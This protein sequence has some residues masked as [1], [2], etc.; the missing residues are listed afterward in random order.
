MRFQRKFR[1]S[2]D[3]TNLPVKRGGC[4]ELRFVSF[5]FFFRP[6]KEKVSGISWSRSI[7][8]LSHRLPFDQKLF[9]H[10]ARLII[11]CA[12]Q[13]AGHDKNASINLHYNLI[14][15]SPLWI[16]PSCESLIVQRTRRMPRHPSNNFSPLSLSLSLLSLWKF[17]K[18]KG[19]KSTFNVQ[20]I[21]KCFSSRK[22]CTRRKGEFVS[23][24]VKII[25]LFAWKKQI[26]EDA[27][28]TIRED[29]TS[30]KKR[31][32]RKCFEILD[33][34][35]PFGRKQG[36]HESS[37]VSTLHFYYSTVINIKL[38]NCSRQFSRE[39]NGCVIVCDKE[40]QRERERDWFSCWCKYALM[41]I[42]SKTFDLGKYHRS[43][44][45]GDNALYRNPWILI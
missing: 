38:V 29:E 40:T 42:R 12:K 44:N 27:L 9:L 1:R 3:P 5:F 11:L 7:D 36:S 20:R 2:L 33:S 16:A 24:R 45:I 4:F 8:P 23:S 37:L 43:V 26:K 28:E 15:M 41:K 31:E 34:P 18:K 39:P 13:I 32:E 22:L 30:F 35:S 21:W 17:K 14:K 10:E 6:Q 25:F 19:E